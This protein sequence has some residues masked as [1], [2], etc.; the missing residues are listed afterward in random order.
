MAFEEIIREKPHLK[1]AFE[2]YEK[3]QKLKECSSSLSFSD[4]LTQEDVHYLMCQL[5]SIFKIPYEGLVP[6][7]EALLMESIDLS[8]LPVSEIT[9]FELPYQQEELEKVLFIISKPY[10]LSLRKKFNLNNIFWTE[11]KCPI[12]NATPSVSLLSKGAKRR[13]YCTYCE[14]I[15]YWKRIGC[16]RCLTE[17]PRDINIITVEQKE[18]MR[19]D[20]CKKCLSYY[21]S[22]ENSLVNKYSLDILDIISLPLDIIAQERGFR[23]HSPNCV[24]ISKT[25]T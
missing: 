12:C 16:P 19:V 8:Q 15:G 13:F 2:I 9:N 5:S 4:K 18:G 11:G 23:R 17:D 21:K 6:L 1:D 25:I 7:E 24:S 20:S 10:F 14:T 3:I 22:F